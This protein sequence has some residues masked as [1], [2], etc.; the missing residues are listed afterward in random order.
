MNPFNAILRTA[1]DFYEARHEPEHLRPLIEWY[2]GTL[3][4]VS[5]AALAGIVLWGM[6]TF[7]AV[8]RNL[9]AGEG[10]ARAEAP[11]VLNK[12]TLTDFL[13]AFE[14]RKSRFDALKK[15]ATA[16]ADPSR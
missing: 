1:R 4:T 16:P 13:A 14:E 8:V 11:E 9:N 7:F 12:K 3:L 10:L 15:S 6:W 2:W 5:V